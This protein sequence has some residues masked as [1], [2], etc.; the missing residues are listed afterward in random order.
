MKVIIKRALISVANKKGIVSFAKYLNT[1]GVTIISTGGTSHLLKE[2]N[3]PCTEVAEITGFPEMMSG[4]V[5]TLHPKIHGGILG[6]RQEHV[7]EASCHDIRWIDL[8]VVN[9]YPFAE[10]IKQKQIQFSTAIENIDIGGPAMIRA[11]AKNMNDVAVVVNPDDYEELIQ[12][13]GNECSLTLENRQALALK[14]FEYTAHYDATIHHYLCA[15][16]KN[17]EELFPER[18]LFPLSK[19]KELRYGENPN[20]RACS[21]QFVGEPK[22]IFRTKQ[23]QGKELSYNNLLDTDAA[24]SCI[25]EFTMPTCVIVKHANP[26]GVAIGANICEAFERALDTD[27]LSAFGGIIALNRICTEKTAY[28]ITQSFFE[29]LLAPGFSKEAKAILS[30][31]I[32]LRVI[33]LS[34]APNFHDREYRSITGGILIQVANKVTP[35][36]MSYRVVTRQ[37][38]SKEIMDEL[39][40][41]WRIVKH[42]KSNAILIAKNYQA[43]GIGGGQVSRIDAVDIAVR[44]ASDRLDNAVLASDAFFPFRDSIDHISTTGIMAIIQP[45]GSLRDQ[46]IINACDEHGIVMVM[47]GVRCFKH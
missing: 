19:V 4:R 40:F 44:K 1:L 2:A 29:V 26:C 13:M 24:I 45:G 15:T 11:A 42:I 36:D 35:A 41:A 28:A 33:E 17:T 27:K 6:C 46:E 22:G 34:D 9:L 38:P 12:Q 21:Y 30:Q 10:I 31:K 47:S 39:F 43:I 14:A 18:L 37:K 32:N 3:V 16:V 8:V 23:L 25:E 5:K 7:E 20:Q